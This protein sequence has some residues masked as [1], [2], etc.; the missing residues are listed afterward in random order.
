MRVRSGVTGFES[1]MA[2]AGGQLLS[3][4]L[5]PFGDRVKEP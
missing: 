1:V 5:R 3:H 2:Y 4:S